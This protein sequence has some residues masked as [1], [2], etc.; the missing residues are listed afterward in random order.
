MN[1]ARKDSFINTAFI[2][3]IIIFAGQATK[4]TRAIQ[5]WDHISGLAFIIIATFIFAT[6]NKV[7]I[8]RKII[9]LI[10]FYFIYFILVSYQFAEFH[11]RFFAIYLCCF[12]I[13]YVLIEALQY[14]FF[15]IFEKILVQFC[16]ISIGFWILLVLA[17]SFLYQLFES[18]SFLTTAT[19]LVDSNIIIYTLNA[20]SMVEQFTFK[21]GNLRIIRNAGFSWEPGGFAVL[22][23]LGIV[24]NMI[25]YRFRIKNNKN[26]RILLLALITTFSTTGYGIL[27][28]LA[29]FYFY[30]IKIKYKG[31]LVPVFIALGVYLLTLPFMLNKVIETSDTKNI[32]AEIKS[33]ILYGGHKTPQRINSFIIDF[34]DFKNNPI[35]GYGGHLDERWTSKLGAN[36]STI[37][38]IGKVFAVFGLV[39]VIFFF[40]LLYKS[41]KLF[42]LHFKFK[43]WIFP[44]LLILFISISYSL[45]FHPLFMC[46]WMHALFMPRIK[47]I[48][49]SS[50]S[51]HELVK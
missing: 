6:Y 19:E 28:I 15:L 40:T 16:K 11:P 21:I 51:R 42:S 50:L 38:G 17:P 32:N 14:R 5:S 48:I 24:I 12:F 45:I 33:S 49:Y 31:L 25:R 1:I 2:F 35:L 43:G 30:N 41:S 20:E 4:F 27:M 9:K 44:F 39:G 8:K 3:I 37:S 18:V 22:I 26:I 13:T 7:V 34:Q 29:L 10:F 46:F 47:P 36:I 23:N